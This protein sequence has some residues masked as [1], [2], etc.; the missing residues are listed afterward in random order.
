[1][2]TPLVTGAAG[3]VGRHLLDALAAEGPVVGWHRPG[4][5]PPA[6][7]GVTWRAVELQ[8]RDSVAAALAADRPAAIYHCAGVA[9]VGD[10][11]AQAE[12]TLASNVVGTA[13]LLAAI[14]GLG[15][16]PRVV[17]TGSATI[18]RPGSEP[19]TE[20]SPVAP[21]TPYGTSKL[22]Q[23]MVTLNECREHGLAAVV[24]R[25][26]NHIGP[27]QSPA[28][29]AA[30]FARQLARIEAGL[31]APT[32]SVGN[33]SAQRD[34][35]DVRDTVRAYMALIARGVPGT[36][37]NVCSGRAVPVQALLDGLR[38]RVAVPV[39]VAVDPAR[40]RPVDTPV[41]VGSHAKLTADTGWTPAFSFD[42]TL[43][44]LL[45]YWRTEVRA[46]RS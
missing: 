21:N 12:D 37:Y 10:S 42:E 39:D 23:E 25:S 11:W 8:Q 2:P 13:N 46:G 36:C 43:D 31:D 14:R 22:A 32:I 33:L 38:A 19:L 18:Y 20:S 41:I 5:A 44:A 29:A 6:V 15:L 17:V 16:R 45:D 35:T 34:L 26:F 9:H 3:F 27:G 28:F 30:S 7:P 1:V 4:T 40:M 24:T